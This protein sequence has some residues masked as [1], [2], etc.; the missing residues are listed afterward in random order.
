MT[1]MAN[2]GSGIDVAVDRVHKTVVIHFGKPV[3]W[4]GLGPEEAMALA[5]AL[6]EKAREVSDKPLTLALSCR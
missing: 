1:V 2:P 4:L 6:V 3:E 5:T